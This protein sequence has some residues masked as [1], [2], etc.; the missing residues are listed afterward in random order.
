VFTCADTSV[1]NP[2]ILTARDISG[3]VNSVLR[4]VTVVDSTAPFMSAL[5]TVVYLDALGQF[6][7]NSS[8]INNGTT[9][10]CAISAIWL[11]DSVFTCADTMALNPVTLFARDISGNINSIVRNVTVIDTTKPILIANDTTIYL[12]P[13]GQF[14]IT[15]A[16]IN[17]GSSDNCAIQS[18]WLSDSVFVCSDT[19]LPNPVTLFARDFSGNIDSIVALVTVID[20]TPPVMQANDTT[21]YLDAF[22]QF[23]INSS[24]INNGTSDNCAIQAIWLSD[25]VFTCA[26]TAALNVVTLFALDVSGNLNS[27]NAN[28]TVIDTVPPVVTT[29]PVVVFLDVFGNA[30]IEGDTVNNGSTDN[31]AIDTITVSPNTFTCADIGAPIVA[32]MTVRDVSGNTS[33]DTATIVVLDNIPPNVVTQSI[34]VYLDQTGNASI[35]ALDVENGSTDACGIASYQLND[36]L[37]NCGDVGVNTVLLTVTDIHGNQSTSPATVNVFDTIAPTIVAVA[38]TVYLNILGIGT[39]NVNRIDDGSFDNCPG[40]TRSISQSSFGCIDVGLNI[41]VTFSVQD[42]SGNISDTIVFVYVLDTIPPVPVAQ[43]I[44]VYLDANGEAGIMKEDVILSLSDSCAVDSTYITVDSFFCASAGDSVQIISVAIDTVANVGFDT[45]YAFVFDTI[46]PTV[47]A[48]NFTVYLN[49]SGWATIDSNTLDSASFDN[50]GIA[51]FSVSR[52]SFFCADLGSPVPV[53]LYALD[54]S[55]ST[56]S[57]LVFVTVLDT[58]PPVAVARDITIYLDV[59]GQAVIAP[60]SLDSLSSDICNNLAFAAS[61]TSFTCIDTNGVGVL[62]TV[63]DGSGNTHQDSAFV[64]VMDTIAPTLVIQSITVYLDSSGVVTFNV[65]DID[66]NTNDACGVDTTFLSDTAFTCAEVGVN[67]VLFTAVDIS[68]NSRSSFTQVT[69]VDTVRP[70]VTIQPDTIWLTT[71]GTAISNVDSVLVSATDACGVD[72]TYLNDTLFDCS[73]VGLNSRTLTVIDVNNNITIRTVS[74]FV[75]DSIPPTL[76]VTDTT[77]YLDAFGDFTLDTSYFDLGSFDNCMPLP[78][79]LL[80][81]TQ[82]ECMNAGGTVTVGLT[83]QDPNGLVTTGTVNILVLDT[84]LPNMFGQ[85]ITVYLDSTGNVSINPMDVDNG[86]NDA[87]GIDSMYLSDSAFTCAD[88][89]NNNIY[90]YALDANQ[91]LDSILITVTVEDTIAPEAWSF[92]HLIFALDSTGNVTIETAQIDSASFDPCGIDT[93]FLSNYDFTCSDVGQSLVVT[94]TVIDSTGN[95]STSQTGISII[96]T[97]APKVLT[98]NDTVFLNNNGWAII[99]PANFNAGTWDSCGVDSLYLDIDS[100]FCTATSGPV[101]IQLFASDIFGNV[102]SASALLWVLD[103]IAPQISC[104]MDTTLFN[105][106]GQCGSSVTFSFPTA[107]DNCAIDNI[108]QIDNSGLQSGDFFP[109]GTTALRYVATDV[110][111]NTDTCGFSITVI[112][113]QPPV[114]TCMPDTFV[115][116]S[117]F[118]F[119]LPLTDDNCAVDSLYQIA[120]IPSGAFYPVGLTVNTYVA[121]DGSGNSD[122]CSFSITRFDYSSAALAGPDTA[123]CV[124]TTYEMLAINPVVGLGQWNILTSGPQIIDLDTHNATVTNLQIG[125]NVFE[126]TIQNGVCPINRDTVNIRVDEAPTIAILEDDTSVCGLDQL[127]ISSNEPEVGRGVWSVPG[128]GFVTDTLRT[129]TVFNFEGDELYEVVWT[130]SNGVCPPSIANRLIR[131]LPVPEIEAGENIVAFSGITVPLDGATAFGASSFLWE[132]AAGLSDASVLNPLATFTETTVM[133]LNA[134]TDSGCTVQDS[135]LLII[136]TLAD[137]PTG[138]TP[139]GDQIN[140]VW[141]IPGIERYPDA[142]VLVFDQVG[143]KVFESVGYP[144]PWD[145]SFNGRP[146]PRASYYWIIDLQDGFNEPFQGI[147]SIMR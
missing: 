10:N 99:S 135:L 5:D 22:G 65:G 77:V 17:N 146:L 141:N 2:V 143:R 23:T 64:T 51:A 83:I 120:G 93:M 48:R 21:I 30:N 40:F 32:T 130:I 115:C 26:D 124:E 147:I 3:N 70:V 59:N 42:A 54:N 50:C 80:D 28:V 75:I 4:H 114:I 116:D 58:I 61:Q 6:T 101:S 38:D 9:D 81:S 37:F 113:T 126:W 39:T 121:M 117:I 90:L 110:N 95:T 100:V 27:I 13:T 7:I 145:G 16:W 97:I 137:I 20:S 84:V 55:D 12:D 98:V 92:S 19:L 118:S 122:T 86:T 123:L 36:S 45:S 43:N 85:N 18:M 47:I 52:D 104:R 41:P 82:F 139:N 119:D 74:V 78:S 132:P 71:N 142:K 53:W 1:L 44:I 24:W 91:N 67:Q 106:N 105:A 102:D 96:D 127:A 76:L 56:D 108:T 107:T 134:T 136:Q 62:L 112:D 68:G 88:L 31:C 33:S 35:T 111:G 72:T 73:H 109:V 79:Y 34:N 128:L 60:D 138:I 11:D 69:V 94:L 103:T 25:S 8:W 14:T 87:C 133:V 29:Q 57:A 46:L 131:N 140:D 129:R 144:Q 125:D 66:V 89:G 63:T 49:S 15:S